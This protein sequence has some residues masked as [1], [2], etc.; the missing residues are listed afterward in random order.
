MPLFHRIRTD[1][2]RSSA[3]HISAT[4]PARAAASDDAS[5]TGDRKSG[6]NVTDNYQPSCAVE[7]GCASAATGRDRI[8]TARNDAESRRLSS[9]YTR[10]P[11]AG[12]DASGN[13]GSERESCRYSRADAKARNVQF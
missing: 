1:L 13:C 7:S 9:S 5:R 11:R 4:F 2:F 8:A 12:N 10:I 6:V 3:H